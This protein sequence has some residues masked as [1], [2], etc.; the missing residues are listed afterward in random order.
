MN[1]HAVFYLDRLRFCDEN[2]RCNLG[3]PSLRTNEA[4]KPPPPIQILWDDEESDYSA[5]RAS[6]TVHFQN[7]SQSSYTG[8]ALV[9][10]TTGLNHSARVDLGEISIAAGQTVTRTVTASALPFCAPGVVVM[11]N[12]AF[13]TTTEAFY[14]TPRHY[15]FNSGCQALSTFSADYL[16]EVLD[17]YL[18]R[19]P[20]EELNSP[21]NPGNF[22]SSVRIGSIEFDEADFEPSTDPVDTD[23]ITID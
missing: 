10:L 17:G 12:I 4:D 7:R 13:Y 16:N 14:T 21:N 1:D 15:L 22:I 8:N 19:M 3:C 5:D 2:D 6:L 18:Y 23:V 20:E 11:A 9:S